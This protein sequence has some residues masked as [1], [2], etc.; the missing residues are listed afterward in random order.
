MP[1]LVSLLKYK[2]TLYYNGYNQIMFF[3]LSLIIKLQIC[4]LL[5]EQELLALREHMSSRPVL[6]G[7]VLLD[8]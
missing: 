7:S 8:L 6:A 1:I 2:N 5:V 3:K 4:L